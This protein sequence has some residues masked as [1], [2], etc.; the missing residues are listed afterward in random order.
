LTEIDLNGVLAT[1]AALRVA[2]ERADTAARDRARRKL[3]R[4]YVERA[5]ERLRAV[6][7]AYEP[8]AIRTALQMIEGA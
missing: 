8:V 2:M 3:H 7:Q 5:G 1:T 6:N 4:H